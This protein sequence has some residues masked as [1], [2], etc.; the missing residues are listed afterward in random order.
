[1]D[2]SSELIHSLVAVIP[3]FLAVVLLFFGVQKSPCDSSAY[4]FHN[5]RRTRIKLLV[6]DGTG[7]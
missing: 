6:W 3:A 4:A 7:V 5:N 2:V 1:M